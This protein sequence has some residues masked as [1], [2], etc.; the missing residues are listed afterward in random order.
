MAGDWLARGATLPLRLFLHLDVGTGP[1]ILIR[2]ARLVK[3]FG[4]RLDT[5]TIL[6]T[7]ASSL[8]TFLPAI[9]KTCPRLRTLRVIHSKDFDMLGGDLVD[10]DIQNSSLL[11]IGAPI[12]TIQTSLN[13]TWTGVAPNTFRHLL[14][15]HG[16]SPDA[17]SLSTTA[18][19]SSMGPE[20]RCRSRH[21]HFSRGSGARLA[22]GGAPPL[23]SKS[24]HLFPTCEDIFTGEPRKLYAV[25]WADCYDAT[26]ALLTTLDDVVSLSHTTSPKRH[27]ISVCVPTRSGN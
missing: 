27:T 5:M 3:Q 4:S 10:D 19:A 21:G 9:R 26:S 20:S 14:S 16:D 25:D 23:R 24:R 18:A 1:L 6:H 12:Q 8:D 11:D 13:F 2:I 7:S 15:V 22:F 17:S